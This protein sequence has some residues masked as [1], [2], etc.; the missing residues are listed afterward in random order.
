MNG[1]MRSLLL[2]LLLQPAPVPEYG[3]EAIRFGTIPAFPVASLVMGAP[4]DERMDVALVVWLI[5]GG[6]RTILFDSGFHR[7]SWI[8][9]FKV[10]DF[11]R[12]DEAVRLAGV[13]PQQVTD[14]V[15]SHAHWDHMGGLELFPNATVWIQRAEF[16]YYTGSAWQEGG[17]K[18]G[19][20]VEDLVLLVRRNAAGKLR[21][22]DGDAKEILPGITVHTGARHTFASQ[23]VRVGGAKPFVLASDNC[24]LYRNLDTR[25]P[26]ATFSPEDRE[27]NLA[28]FDRMVALAG[29]RERV[30]PG[31]DPLQ[32]ERFPARGRVARIR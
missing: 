26:V 8:E 7:P 9:R 15:I 11:V 16:E 24:Y 25:L 10:T 6:G 13:E 23:Y 12:P 14:L 17:R 3:I 5:R 1:R 27:A 4:K 31:H 22:V 18:G 30:L 29:A 32:F 28:A 21:L 20:D 2:L 19:I